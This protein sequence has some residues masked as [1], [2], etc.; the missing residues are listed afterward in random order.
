MYLDPSHLQASLIT[1]AAR[2]ITEAAPAA[3]PDAR[4]IELLEQL[5]RAAPGAVATTKRLLN[6][7]LQHHLDTHGKD[8]VELSDALFAGAEA[9]AG[10][11]AFLTKN[12]APVGIRGTRTRM[13][14]VPHR[15]CDRRHAT[16]HR[17]RSVVSLGTANHAAPCCRSRAPLRKGP[18]PLQLPIPAVSH[19][20]WNAIDV[21]WN[22]AATGRFGSTFE[23]RSMTFHTRPR[24]PKATKKLNSPGGVG[25]PDCARP[26]R[27]I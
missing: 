13:A 7:S 19:R 21:G 15:A 18:A 9:R 3:D 5:R 26:G 27:S 20:E 8:M 6:R 23:T 16:I 24:R 17:N 1:P 25:R 11:Q 4:L 12:T 22:C 2:L 14:S 10:L